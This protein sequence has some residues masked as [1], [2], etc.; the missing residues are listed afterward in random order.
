MIITVRPRY[1]VKST[2]LNVSYTLLTSYW[3]Y[4]DVR[5]YQVIHCHFN[6]PNYVCNIYNLELWREFDV[7]YT[8]DVTY[9]LYNDVWMSELKG[10]P[11]PN[12]IMVLKWPNSWNMAE[13]R[14]LPSI[15]DAKFNIK[16][17]K[18]FIVQYS[19]PPTP[20]AQGVELNFENIF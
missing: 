15:S 10:C 18:I 14:V 6:R 3:P 5:M 17:I 12:I 1:D 19:S 4:N 13:K 9:G 11:W 8:A 2:Y 16:L 7:Y 20:Y